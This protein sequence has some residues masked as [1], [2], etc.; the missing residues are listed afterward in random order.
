MAFLV[1]FFV[2]L[3]LLLAFFSSFEL[4]LVVCSIFFFKLFI[5]I[6]TIFIVTT[7]NRGEGVRPTNNS[8]VIF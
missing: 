1:V 5:G 7:Q 3:E 6:F 2:V 8:F 4:F